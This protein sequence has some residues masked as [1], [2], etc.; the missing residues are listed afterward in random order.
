MRSD[1]IGYLLALGVLA[2]CGDDVARGH[3]AS[4]AAATSTG[5]GGSTYVPSTGYGGTTYVSPGYGGTTY[6]SPGTGSGGSTYVAPIT[7]G[8]AGSTVIG[9]LGGSTGVSGSTGVGPGTATGSIALNGGYYASGAF[10]GYLYTAAGTGSTISPPCGTGACF[11]TQACVNGTVPKVSSATAYSAEWGALV[12]WNIAQE[13]APPN[14]AAAVALDGK[15]IKL[16][17]TTGASPLPAGMR[18]KVTSAGVEYCTD[19]TGGTASVAASSLRKECWTAGGT[20]LPAGS[21]VAAV[22]VQITSDG[23]TDKKF[24][25]CVSSLSIE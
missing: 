14:P 18:V 20:A 23:A 4:D 17:L 9:V 10:K 16:S 1:H 11:T 13:A 25:F 5:W 21:T 8:A 7:G 3:A 12:G 15:T 2:A 6:V 22:A 19:L 24:D